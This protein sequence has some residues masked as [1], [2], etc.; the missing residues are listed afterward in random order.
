MEVETTEGGGHL[1]G[2][3]CHGRE[4]GTLSHWRK[5]ACQAVQSYPT[6]AF[7]LTP[8]LLVWTCLLTPLKM[9]PLSADQHLTLNTMV[10]STSPQYQNLFQACFARHLPQSP[11]LYGRLEVKLGDKLF[12]FKTGSPGKFPVKRKSPSDYRRDQRRRKPPGKGMPTPGNHG[13]GSVAPGDPTIF[14][15]FIFSMQ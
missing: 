15:I 3:P 13:V 7:S 6:T 14:L 2:L 9:T 11:G 1:G 10:S 12:N 4:L 5:Q 8:P